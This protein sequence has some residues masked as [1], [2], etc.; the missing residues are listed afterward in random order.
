MGGYYV[1]AVLTFIVDLKCFYCLLR[2][3][4]IASEYKYYVRTYKCDKGKCEG[5]VGFSTPA[6]KLSGL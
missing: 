4:G 3:K 5:L 2:K 1:P 6:A